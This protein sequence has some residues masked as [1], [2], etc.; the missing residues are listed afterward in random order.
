[1]KAG[2]MLGKFRGEINHS[3]SL[4]DLKVHGKT[5]QELTSLVQT[6]RIFSS[7]IGMQC[8]ISKCARL[9]MKKVKAVQ[10]E[11][12]ELPNGETIKSL[13]D[14]KGYQYLGVLLFNSV[15]SKE[16]KDIITKDYYRKSRKI[17]K[18]ILI[19]GKTIQAINVKA[20]SII[21]YG[22]GIVEWR[23]NGLEAIDRNTRKL[24]TMY[25]SLHPRVDVDRLY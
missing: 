17:L 4:E 21:R 16:I 7:D 10:S 23:K 12:I 15:K 25:R 20:V 3:L 8:G 13:K 5:I 22:A 24:L 18:A 2:Y 14:G 6:V 1:M 9:E 19:A 11:G